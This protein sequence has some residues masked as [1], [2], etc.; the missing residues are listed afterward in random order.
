MT[1]KYK[2]LVLKK[3]FKIIILEE[4]SFK[5]VQNLT[6]N[7]L[8]CFMCFHSDSS[9]NGNWVVIIAPTQVTVYR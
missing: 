8:Q 1:L 2:C 9:D 5:Y 7:V 6:D 4:I 3:L